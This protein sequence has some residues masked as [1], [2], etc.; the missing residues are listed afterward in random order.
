MTDIQKWFFFSMK[1]ES[2]GVLKLQE[3]LR[4]AKSSK[5]HPRRT[6]KRWRDVTVTRSKGSTFTSKH[7]SGDSQLIGTKKSII[8]H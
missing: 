6:E 7:R 2:V 1:S 3:S 5:L 4:I 8:K